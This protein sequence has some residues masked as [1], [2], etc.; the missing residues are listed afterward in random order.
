MLKRGQFNVKAAQWSDYL[1]CYTVAR[2]N[3]KRR[4]FPHDPSRAYLE[5]YSQ[6]LQIAMRRKESEILVEN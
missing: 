5:Q 2:M 4:K 6:L 1:N 3:S